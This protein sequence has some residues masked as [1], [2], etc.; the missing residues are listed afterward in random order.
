MRGIRPDGWSRIGNSLNWWV[1]VRS[2]ADWRPD[3]D[4]WIVILALRRRA[5]G[6]IPHRPDGWSIFP[7]LELGKNL[8]LFEYWEASERAAEMSGRMQA[9]IEAS[10]YSVGSGRK[11]YIAQNDDTGLS[12]ARSG[13]TRR[14]D[15]WTSGQMGI[16]TGRHVVWTADRETE[17]F[18]LFRSAESSE[19]ALTSGIHVYNIFTHKWF[20]PNTEWGQ[21]TN[22]YPGSHRTTYSWKYLNRNLSK[23]NTTRKY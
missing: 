15:G 4:I 5:S 16:R 6:G 20:C 13:W 3:G 21:N 23:N 19:N 11:R 2:K 8:R 17:I 1:R 7:L 10:R 22:N 12:S 14:P 18:Y 9:R